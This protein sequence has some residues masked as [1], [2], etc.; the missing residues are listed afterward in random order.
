MQ[1]MEISRSGLDVEW[2]R[3]ELIAQNL[4]NATSTRAAGETPYQP[5]RLVSGAKADFGQ[6]M[7]SVSPESLAGVRILGLEPAKT[8]PRRVHEPGHPHADNEGFV[9][10]P[11]LDHASE[12]TLL[13]KT[14][15][16][17]EANLVALGTARQMYTK[18]LELG[19]KA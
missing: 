1:A 11:G 18:A 19:R 2:R 16:A 8:S 10:Y 5:M 15:R 6:L 17:Y 7:G 3:L 14:A 9:T 13:V 12:M 4:A